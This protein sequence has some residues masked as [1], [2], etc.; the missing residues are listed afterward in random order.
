MEKSLQDKLTNELVKRGESV[1]TA[2]SVAI[3]LAKIIVSPEA[4]NILGQAL[5]ASTEGVEQ[6]TT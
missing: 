2:R 5:V 3:H 4:A 1:Y 6:P